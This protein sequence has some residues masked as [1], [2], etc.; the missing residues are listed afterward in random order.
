MDEGVLKG[1]RILVVEDEE[2]IAM[3]LEDYLLDLGCEL[4]GHA[5]TVS[6]AMSLIDQTPRLDAALLDMNLRGELVTPVATALA[7]ANIPF[8]FMTG[9][10]ADAATGF[11]DAPTIGKPFD[12][13]GLRTALVRLI[14]VAGAAKR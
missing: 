3:L 12:Q 10:G 14:S 5:G 13:D 6:V 1:R 11:A 4:A 7:A 9:L 8:C 2:M